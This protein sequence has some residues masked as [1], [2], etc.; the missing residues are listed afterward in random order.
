MRE[1]L[2]E[3]CHDQWSNWME[4][5][6]QKCTHNIHTGEMTIPAW[7][8]DRWKRQ[9]S[10]KYEFLSESEK[11]SDLKEADKFIKLWGENDKDV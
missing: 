5:L 6:F 1:K 3:L 9:M 8:V 11:E 2:A 7:A 4:Y 10:T